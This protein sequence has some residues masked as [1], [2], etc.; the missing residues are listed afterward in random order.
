MSAVASFASVLIVI[1]LWGALRPNQFF[2]FLTGE[3]YWKEIL[4]GL[5]FFAVLNLLPDY[6]SLL[7]SRYVI[8]LM[9]R[10]RSLARM[11]LLLLLDLLVTVGIGFAAWMLLSL[12]VMS[13]ETSW[14][15]FV[16]RILPLTASRVGGEGWG[17]AGVFFYSTFFTSVWVWLFAISTQ[18]VR[19]AEYFGIGLNRLK[20]LLDIQ[21]KPIQSL[22]VMSILLLTFA[23]LFIPFFLE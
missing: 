12:P 13:R 11:I 16:E 6:L 9:Q 15:I 22:G 4:V 20:W 5:A 2:A 21:Q 17:A 19:L 10:G 7:E 23:Y 14:Q 3:F 1:L 8:K 18:A